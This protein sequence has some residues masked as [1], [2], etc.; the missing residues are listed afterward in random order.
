YR[1][2]LEGLLDNLE[3]EERAIR[4]FM[5]LDVKAKGEFAKELMLLNMKGPEEKFEAMRGYK[6]VFKLKPKGGRIYFTFGSKRR[7]KVIGILWG[8]DDKAKSTYA[9]ELLVKY[10]A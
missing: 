7:W 10:K 1:E 8:E 5:D 4:D 2:L 9:K 3:F 6:G